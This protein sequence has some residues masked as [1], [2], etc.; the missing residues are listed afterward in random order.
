MLQN[1]ITVEGLKH[2][3]SKHWMVGT[4]GDQALATILTLSNIEDQITELAAFH[5]QTL[6]SKDDFTW[7]GFCLLKCA[8]VVFDLLLTKEMRKLE[9]GIDTYFIVS[10]N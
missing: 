6:H 5:Y 8:L 9:V 1:E 2:L 10:Y 4:V 7:C 3:G